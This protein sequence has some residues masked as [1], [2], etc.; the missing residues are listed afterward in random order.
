MPPP[1]LKFYKDR[2]RKEEIPYVGF[3]DES[4]EMGIEGEVEAYVVNQAEYPYVVTQVIH[5]KKQEGNTL[6]ATEGTSVEI[7]D[8]TLLPFT[9]VKVKLKWKPPVS[10]EQKDWKPLVGDIFFDGYFVV[11]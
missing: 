6:I 3:P 4:I 1:S 11:R 7:E 10:E 2:T 8:K 5:A 9:P